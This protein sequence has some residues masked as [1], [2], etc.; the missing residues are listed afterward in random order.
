MN[1]LYIKNM[2]E[3][4]ADTVNAEICKSLINCGMPIFDIE[5]VINSVRKIKIWQGTAE[6]NKLIKLNREVN[7]IENRWDVRISI[8][9]NEDLDEFSF[10]FDWEAIWEH[11]E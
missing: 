6:T 4:K 1:N 5:T 2:Y 10:M 7:R 3:S 9:F 8:E 11:V